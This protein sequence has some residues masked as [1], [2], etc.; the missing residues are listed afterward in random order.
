MVGKGIHDIQAAVTVVCLHPSSFTAFWTFTQWELIVLHS[1]SDR[2]NCHKKENEATVWK[3]SFK[4]L[5]IVSDIIFCQCINLCKT[6]CAGSAHKTHYL[7]SSF[8]DHLRTLFLYSL[9]SLSSLH[10]GLLLD[11]IESCWCERNP[12]ALLQCHLSSVLTLVKT[13]RLAL[14]ISLAS[15]INL[16]ARDRWIW[17]VWCT[18]CSYFL[19]LFL[20]NLTPF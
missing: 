6:Q 3:S 10:N 12:Q 20:P 5:L 19:H 2:Y 16:F 14:D 11:F 13:L 9:G 4:Q 1:S 18:A 7:L 8:G 17:R 15:R